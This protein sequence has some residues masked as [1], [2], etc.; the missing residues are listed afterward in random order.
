MRCTCIHAAWS[1]AAS[2]LR[3]S[4][5]KMSFTETDST[6]EEFDHALFEVRRELVPP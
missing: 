4:S 3:S 2:V 1:N 6:D 5:E